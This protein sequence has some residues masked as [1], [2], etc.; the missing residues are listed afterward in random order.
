[1]ALNTIILF[2][3][4]AVLTT[5]YLWNYLSN[6]KPFPN[7]KVVND[8][9]Y[10]ELK[11][12]Y[13]F[14]VAIVSVALAIAVFVG[15][16]TKKDIENQLK[17]SLE[18]TT[19]LAIEN[20]IRTSANEQRTSLID[21]Q[22]NR[23]EALLNSFYTV[24]SSLKADLNGVSI[25][26]SKSRNEI[27]LL[28][29]KDILKRNF[30]LVDNL[31]GPN[32]DVA[33][34]STDRKIAFDTLITSLG[35]KLPVFEKPPIIFAVSNKGLQIYNI[36]V[37]TKTFTLRILPPYFESLDPKGIFDIRLLISEVE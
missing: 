21:S 18:P 9:R 16:G 29:K 13:E 8:I 27:D 7:S 4:A 17:A 3:I 25:N 32:K 2:F 28:N 37:T 5:Y 19:K 6:R 20:E 24:I 11:S 22:I 36:D 23:Q 34:G 35:T 33:E 14:L 31:T 10:Y 30:Y 12:K 26:I 15:L 1:M